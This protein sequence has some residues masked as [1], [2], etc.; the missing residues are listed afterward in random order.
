MSRLK[1]RYAAEIVPAL[2]ER[3]GYAKNIMQVPRVTKLTHGRG[4]G[5]GVRR[6]IAGAALW[7]EKPLEKQQESL[8]QVVAI[9]R[10]QLGEGFIEASRME[11]RFSSHLKLECD[12]DHAGM[13]QGEVFLPNQDGEWV[14]HVR[15]QEG[16]ASGDSGAEPTVMSHYLE[17]LRWCARFDPK[18]LYAIFHANRSLARGLAISEIRNL[19]DLAGKPEGFAGWPDYWRGIAEEELETSS[20]LLKKAL[21]A[22]VHA[23]DWDLASDACFELGKTYSRRGKVDAANRIAQAALEVADRANTRAA[24]INAARLKGTLL[25]HWG[26]TREGLEMLEMSA[27]LV[28]DPVR[29]AIV[30]STQ[31]W[32][33]AVSGSYAS[34]A[35]RL[36]RGECLYLETGHQQVHLLNSATRAILCIHDGTRTNAISG[37]ERM[38]SECND[39][40]SCQFGVYAEETLAKLYRLDHDRELAAA[41]LNSARLTRLKTRMAKTPLESAMVAAIR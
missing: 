22:A 3:F 30:D 38:A 23:Q 37:L 34:A 7:P 32:F 41:K 27:E 14:D 9:I 12:L 17:S 11:C 1:D 21:R 36:E 10:R 2:R 24:R 4:R 29:R 16:T 5:F 20:M 33:E 40:G 15:L 19:L 18:T 39:G 6:D 28:D 25:L 13:R 8:R 31:A 35:R 26:D